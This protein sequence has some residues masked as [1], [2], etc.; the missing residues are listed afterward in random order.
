ML[1]TV[2]VATAGAFLD[3][4]LLSKELNKIGT[5]RDVDD[6]RES[7]DASRATVV[8]DDMMDDE[9]AGFVVVAATVVDATPPAA[10]SGAS[11]DRDSDVAFVADIVVAAVA[12]TTAGASGMVLAASSFV[13]SINSLI[14]G[15][16]EDDNDDSSTR[17]RFVGLVEDVADDNDI[18]LESVVGIGMVLDVT[19]GGFDAVWGCC[20]FFCDGGC[21]CC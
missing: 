3:A 14:D 12:T 4:L 21:R 9:S 2:I 17:A 5:T 1:L 15:A 16:R 19:L 7:I 18:G 6:D 20:C 8:E 11:G 10:S 13:G